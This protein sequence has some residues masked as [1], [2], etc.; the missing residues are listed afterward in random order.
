MNEVPLTKEQREFATKW[1]NLIYTFLNEK[2][3]PEEDYYDIVV[4]GFLRAV[5][6]YLS[7][8]ALQRYSFSTIAWNNMRS[9]LSGHFKSQ[10]CQKRNGYT[11]SIHTLT[12]GSEPVR[13]EEALSA[14][15]QM[16]MQLETELLLHDL[17][18]RATR[19]QMAVVHMRSAGYNMREIAKRQSIPMKRVQEMLGEIHDLLMVVCHG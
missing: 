2:R 11:I 17:A 3:L 7:K 10:S 8:P 9:C 1:H 13:L 6:E 18:Q 5:K 19:Q 12:Y 15:D 14:P 4:F 16:M